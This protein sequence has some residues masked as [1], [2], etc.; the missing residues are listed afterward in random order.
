MRKLLT[1]KRSPYIVKQKSLCISLSVT[2]L[3]GQ[4]EYFNI[5]IAGEAIA[6]TEQSYL[7]SFREPTQIFQF[8]ITRENE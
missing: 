4:S 6:S 7:Y 2:P 1:G 8:Q 3:L 5:V